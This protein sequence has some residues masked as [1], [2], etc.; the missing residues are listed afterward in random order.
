MVIYLYL[1]VKRLID[2]VLSSLGIIL[3]SPI[4][5]ILIIAIKFGF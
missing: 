3:L 1:K 4:F 2:I 5:V